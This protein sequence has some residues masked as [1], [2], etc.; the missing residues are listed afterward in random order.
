MRVLYNLSESDTIDNGASGITTAFRHCLGHV[1]HSGCTD[2]GQMD[3]SQL[4]VISTSIGGIWNDAK[5]Q[6]SRHL[7]CTFI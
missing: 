4:E 6:L 5:H 7:G 2:L 3:Q 1:S